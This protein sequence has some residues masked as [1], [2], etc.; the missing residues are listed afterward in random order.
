MADF[1][2]ETARRYLAES[3]NLGIALPALGIAVPFVGELDRARNF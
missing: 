2:E 3:Q 1:R